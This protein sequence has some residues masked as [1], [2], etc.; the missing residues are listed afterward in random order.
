MVYSAFPP[1]HGRHIAIRRK[2]L[3][4]RGGRNEQIQRNTNENM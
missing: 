2:S 1:L 3:T 4:S